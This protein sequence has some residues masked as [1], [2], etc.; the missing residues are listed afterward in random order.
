MTCISFAL[1]FCKMARQ[2]NPE[3]QLA[4]RIHRPCL[5]RLASMKAIQL[6]GVSLFV[7]QGPSGTVDYM[8]IMNFRWEYRRL[9]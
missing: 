9:A 8:L 1:K 7:N 6:R 3:E 5:L 2:D 4:F